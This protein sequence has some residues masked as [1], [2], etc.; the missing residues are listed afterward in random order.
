[1]QAAHNVQV[2]A[3]LDDAASMAEDLA[4]QLS[5]ARSKGRLTAAER[6]RTQSLMVSVAVRLKLMP[7]APH[8]H[9]QH[10][11]WPTHTIQRMP[12]QAK[13]GASMCFNAL[14]LHEGC[15][16]GLTIVLDGRASHA[17]VASR[18]HSCLVRRRGRA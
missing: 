7:N 4:R 16:L 17:L 2:N 14:Q 18:V 3:A 10:D 15:R 13:Y 8:K 5:A 11:S 12:E 1:M 9:A 6:K